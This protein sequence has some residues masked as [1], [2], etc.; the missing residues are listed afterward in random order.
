[1]TTEIQ[2]YYGEIDAEVIMRDILALHET[3]NLHIAIYDFHDVSMYI[4]SATP[5][6]DGQY[7]P[8]YD[9]P[10]L[11]IDLKTQF[12]LKVHNNLRG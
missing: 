12:A 11:K 8:A 6:I 3:G 2:K 9:E 7:S 10:Y 4:A 1:M 5:Y